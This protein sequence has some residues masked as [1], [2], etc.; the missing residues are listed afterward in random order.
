M[1]TSNQMFQKFTLK[2]LDIQSGSPRVFGKMKTKLN[3]DNADKVEFYVDDELVFSDDE[4]PFEWILDVPQ[5]LHT[6]ETIAYK[7]QN[8]SKDM[9]DIFFFI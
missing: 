6:F 5:G 4:E 2:K 1:E 8:I 3:V 9:R 7:G